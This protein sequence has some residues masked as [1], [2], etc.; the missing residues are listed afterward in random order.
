MPFRPIL[1]SELE[2]LVRDETLHD[3]DTQTTTTQIQ[4]QLGHEYVR[5]VRWLSTHWPESLTEE[6]TVTLS[7]GSRI[8]K[9]SL[10]PSRVDS[11]FDRLVKIERQVGSRWL[12]VQQAITS[13]DMVVAPSTPAVYRVTYLIGVSFDNT[14]D[15]AHSGVNRQY[16]LPDGMQPVIVS[17]VA[18]WIRQRHDDPSGYKY[19]LD[20]AK[21]CLD[22]LKSGL[23]RM[24]ETAP[25]CGLAYHTNF[26]SDIRYREF[27][28][29]W[30]LY[31]ASELP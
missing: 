1:G 7:S 17:R 4:A 8:L 16:Y 26:A 14:V 6:D 13:D 27:P 29:G 5:A 3:S 12:Q 28:D 18:A 21:E 24:S 10:S 23:D 30:E 20:K 9:S 2:T 22:E 19:H 11:Q 25:V 15:P 31:R